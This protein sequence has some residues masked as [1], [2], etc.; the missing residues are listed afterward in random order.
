MASDFDFIT[1]RIATGAALST[2]DDVNQLVA[3]GITHVLDARAE[4]DDGQLLAGHPAIS[5]K[6]NPTQDDGQTKTPGYFATTLNFALPALAQPHTKCIFHCA[7]G[8]NRGPS[9]ALCVMLAL[10]WDFDTAV[11]LM[12]AKR[13]VVN[14]AYAKDALAAVNALGYV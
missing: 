5:Y 14:I 8:V 2:L 7:A 13:P 9:N 10:G 11:A 3:A 4:F 1:T 6:W 12:H